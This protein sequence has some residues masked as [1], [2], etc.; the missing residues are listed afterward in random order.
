MSLP[1]A[2]GINRAA[3]MILQIITYDRKYPDYVLKALGPNAFQPFIVHLKD[4]SSTEISGKVATAMG[5][6]L[7]NHE[8]ESLE[9]KDLINTQI[10]QYL[11]WICDTLGNDVTEP[12][13]LVSALTALGKNRP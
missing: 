12:A 8:I 5:I 9:P 1:S 11:K 2:D 3:T 10:D 7:C 4:G 13:E 6:L